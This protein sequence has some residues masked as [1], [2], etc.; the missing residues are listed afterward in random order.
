[1]FQFISAHDIVTYKHNNIAYLVVVLRC[2]QSRRDHSIH[3]VE[4]C[5]THRLFVKYL[6]VNFG[7]MLTSCA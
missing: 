4:S 1:M 6:Q 7:A 3:L 2:R 5:D